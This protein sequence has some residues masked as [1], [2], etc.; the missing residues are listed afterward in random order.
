MC[1]IAGF[2]SNEA[3][4]RNSDLSWIEQTIGPLS[5][6][7]A[8][9]IEI[10]T[11][12]KSVDHMIRHFD[13]LMEFSFHFSLISDP[14]FFSK[15]EYLAE[16]LEKALERLSKE[17]LTEEIESLSQDIGDFIW[18]IRAEVIKNVTRTNELINPDLLSKGPGRPQ[19]FVAWAIERST[20]NIDRLEVRG[21]DSA[22]ISIQIMTAGDSLRPMI[23][24]LTIDR[25]FKKSS[26]IQNG[27]SIGFQGFKLPSRGLS[28]NFSYKVANLVGH[29]GDNTKHIRNA[30]RNDEELWNIAAL[31]HK[32]NIIAHTRWASNGIISLSN[33]H[34]V[35][36]ELYEKEDNQSIDDRNAQFVSKW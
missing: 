15:V 26:R 30:V 29:L 25:V 23:E 6:I 2:L 31:T 13:Q 22:G 35:D 27:V 28:L 14:E 36:G 4:K 7:S 11:L 24:E 1:G 10:S 16:L 32:I 12:R 9:S 33:C 34:P 18:Q 17:P 21:R 20:E 3:W 8:G 5:G 19:R